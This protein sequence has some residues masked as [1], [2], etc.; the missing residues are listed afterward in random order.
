MDEYKIHHKVN[1]FYPES[2]LGLILP[3]RIKKQ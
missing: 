1:T 2:S 3:V